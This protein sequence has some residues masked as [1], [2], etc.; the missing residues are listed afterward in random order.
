MIYSA[1]TIACLIVIAYTLLVLECFLPTSGLL[2]I[3]STFFLVAS[4]LFGFSVNV[5]TGL[6]VILIIAAVTPLIFHLLVRLWPTT[7][8]GKQIL[9]LQPL[10]SLKQSSKNQA[11]V[12]KKTMYSPGATQWLKTDQRCNCF[13]HQTGIALTDLKPNGIAKIDGQ[14]MDVMSNGHFIPKGCEIVTT[15]REMGRLYVKQNDST[16]RKTPTDSEHAKI[17]TGLEHSLESII[18]NQ[19]A[20]ID[21]TKPR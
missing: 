9:N 19:A 15:H 20:P 3:F 7:R 13:I 6:V 17:H 1:I 4:V 5:I 14:P 10:P 11:E 16:H 18:N 8:I 2:A 12:A 21:E